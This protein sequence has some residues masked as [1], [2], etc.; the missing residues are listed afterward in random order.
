M[1]YQ[2]ADLFIF[3]EMLNRDP[4]KDGPV[5]IWRHQG[6]DY[7]MICISGDKG[8]AAQLLGLPTLLFDDREENLADVVNKG[9]AQNAGILVR[10]GEARDKRV[11]PWNRRLVINDPHDWVYRSWQFARRF[12]Q[13]LSLDGRPCRHYEADAHTRSQPFHISNR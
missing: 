11:H 6:M 3:T 1:F 8:D 9:S 7:N 5:D 4:D 10:K 13:P 2:V 12:P